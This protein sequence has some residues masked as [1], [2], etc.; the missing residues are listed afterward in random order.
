M[1]DMHGLVL[2]VGAVW[3]DRE[4]EQRHRAV[5]VKRRRIKTTFNPPSRS[6]THDSLLRD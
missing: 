6:Y 1:K 2:L 5:E 4:Q 3:Y